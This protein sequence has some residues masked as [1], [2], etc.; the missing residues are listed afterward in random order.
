[1]AIPGAR[2]P[3][4]PPEIE[5]ARKIL[6]LE[7]RQ[8]L[9]DRAVTTGLASFLPGWQRRIDRTG[10][11]ELRQIADGVLAALDGYAKLGQAA[12][13]EQIEAALDVLTG[14]IPYPP[15]PGGSPVREVGGAPA[16]ASPLSAPER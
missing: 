12:R 7:K 14:D 6:E 1:M 3:S 5:T 15:T 2:K 4:V 8:G 9:Q 10:R 16:A 11:P 13:A